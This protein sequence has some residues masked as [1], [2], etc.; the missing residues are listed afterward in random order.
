M[1]CVDEG[2][3]EAALSDIR[4]KI[5]RSKLCHCGFGVVFVFEGEEVL[6]WS[7]FVELL[8]IGRSLFALSRPSR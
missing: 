3:E 4:L 8:A 2:F 6:D 7:R 1:A 5:Q